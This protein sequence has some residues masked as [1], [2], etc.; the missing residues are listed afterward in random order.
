MITLITSHAGPRLPDVAA[1][2]TEYAPDNEE[3]DNEV[4]GEG[5]NEV[6]G[7]VLP[8]Q[9]IRAMPVATAVRMR[10]L[11]VAPDLIQNQGVR[12]IISGF[13]L[14]PPKAVVIW[15]EPSPPVTF[16][17]GNHDSPDE[18]ARTAG[19]NRRRAFA[20]S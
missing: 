14:G 20:F 11:I 9:A 15:T 3:G 8:E 12:Y 4:P 1:S 5:D 19:S 18:Q 16:S 6:P 17:Y 13:V 2:V 7:S 10:N